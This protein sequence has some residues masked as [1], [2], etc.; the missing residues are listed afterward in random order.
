MENRRKYYVNFKGKNSGAWS[1]DT[2]N[3]RYQH[4]YN[5]LK[6]YDSGMDF[7]D[8]KF[9]IKNAFVSRIYVSAEVVKKYPK[10]TKEFGYLSNIYDNQLVNGKH[11]LELDDTKPY[12]NS[13]YFDLCKL[14]DR[15]LGI[16][17]EHVVPGEV[18]IN[19][20]VNR[21][22]NGN[23]FLKKDF[24]KIFNAIYICLVTKE[25]DH[26]ILN[27]WKDS[28]PDDSNSITNQK[29]PYINF[30]FARYDGKLNGV[31]KNVEIHGWI[32]KDGKLIKKT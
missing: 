22:K 8:L 7:E 10:A 14:A 19:D 23:S 31:G 28:M 30:P 9:D 29:L 24:L 26:N 27:K 3:D 18:Y 13:T 15:A 21:I 5:A 6:T 32:I 1:R 4:I 16:R 11:V 17:V 25:E 2:L 20:A 12:I